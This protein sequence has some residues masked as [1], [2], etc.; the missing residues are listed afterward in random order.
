M[1]NATDA[2]VTLTNVGSP[3]GKSEFEGLDVGPPDEEAPL[4]VAAD[5]RARGEVRVDAP[6]P[7]EGGRVPVREGVEEGDLVPAGGVGD[8]EDAHARLV[9]G[10]VEQPV[11]DVVVV[12]DGARV[13][14]ESV[15]VHRVGQVGDVDDDGAG[16]APAVLLLQL[17]VEE[18]EL[19]VVGE[20]DLV[21]ILALRI[22]D[23]SEVDDVV[24][25]RDVQDVQAR[26][27]EAAVEARAAEGDLATG[28][29]TALHGDDLRVVD[30]PVGP[31][32]H[33]LRACWVRQVVDAQ[34]VARAAAAVEVARIG[35]DGDVVRRA[36]ADVVDGAHL[37]DD[38]LIDLRQID[39]LDARAALRDDV[40]VRAEGLD[41]APDAPGTG[42]VGDDARARRLGHVD[43][44]RAVEMPEQGVLPPVGRDVAP[45]V[46]PVGAGAEIRERE[47]GEQLDARRRRNSALRPAETRS[48][49]CPRTARCGR[50]ACDHRRD[51]RPARRVPR[52]NP[53]R[54]QHASSSCRFPV[55]RCLSGADRTQSVLQY[56]S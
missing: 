8:V 43:D 9:V 12:G 20:P 6:Q 51:R 28:E 3:S 38:A 54:A 18:D 50:R 45:A 36:G 39:D 53:A 29:G 16:V 25:V 49:R 1:S 27:G 10:R 40:G 55:S 47:P 33:E 32:A 31:D 37:I 56:R 42:N 34:A 30:V 23:A 48:S 14:L 19:L 46:A 26:L 35:I 7:V 21:G 15:D 2:S 22:H 17:V 5:D 41:V 13:V 24:L 44:G 52:S 4:D 11:G